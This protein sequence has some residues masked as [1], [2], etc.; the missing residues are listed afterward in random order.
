MWS[1]FTSKVNDNVNADLAQSIYCGDAAGRA[2]GIY[3][4][5][6]DSDL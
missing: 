3:K 2:T 4:D 5:F 6:T 1:F